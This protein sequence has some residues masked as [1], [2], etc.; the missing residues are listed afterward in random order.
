MITRFIP[1][2][3]ESRGYANLYQCE[4]C[5]CWIPAGY[6]M[7]VLDYN[8]CPWCGAKNEEDEEGE[9]R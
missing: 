3:P 1:V 8:F 7:R 5:G 6:Y 4:H 9:E 2:N